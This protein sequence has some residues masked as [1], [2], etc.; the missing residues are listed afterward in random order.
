M[1]DQ[2]TDCLRNLHFADDVAPKMMSDFKMRQEMRFSN[3]KQ[4]RS[5]IESDP[6]GLRST[7]T[8][9]S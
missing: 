7:G 2:E 5:K 8:N 9:K 3:R 4:Q 6:P 1:G